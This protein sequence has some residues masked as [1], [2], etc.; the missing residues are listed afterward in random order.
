MSVEEVSVHVSGSCIESLSVTVS[1]C[2]M[3]VGVV[4]L[5]VRRTLSPRTLYAVVLG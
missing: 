4:E 1:V 5:Y 2:C 3:P